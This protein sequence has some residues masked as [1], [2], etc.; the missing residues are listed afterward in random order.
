VFYI[1][2]GLTEGIHGYG[3][4]GGWWIAELGSW[5]D[6]GFDGLKLNQGQAGGL[7]V[8]AIRSHVLLISG[9]DHNNV[10]KRL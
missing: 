3:T 8:Q 9:T 1:P 4:S 10:E 6:D 7:T 2:I 5:L